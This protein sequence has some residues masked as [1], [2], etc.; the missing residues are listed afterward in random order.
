MSFHV[1]GAAEWQFEDYIT[2]QF[3]LDLKI[4]AFLL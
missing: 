1:P 4:L 2:N 3:Q